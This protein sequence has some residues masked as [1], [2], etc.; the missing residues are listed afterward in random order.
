MNNN[1]R[2]LYAYNK[3]AMQK[4]TILWQPRGHFLKL[5][6]QNTLLVWQDFYIY[7]ICLKHNLLGTTKFERAQKILGKYPQM[8]PGRI[9]CSCKRLLADKRS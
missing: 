3:K 7:Y 9:A 6:G 1:K 8:P 5:R 2:Y 4:A